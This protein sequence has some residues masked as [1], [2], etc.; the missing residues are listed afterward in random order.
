MNR[1]KNISTSRSLIV[2][3]CMR[4]IDAYCYLVDVLQR[5]AQQLIFKVSKLTLLL[6]KIYLASDLLRF[7][8]Y[9]ITKRC[10]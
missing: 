6:L 3:C 1:A 8:L 9:D 10:D 7:N 4:D 5:I 2:T